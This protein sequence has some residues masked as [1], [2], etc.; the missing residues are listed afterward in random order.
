[1]DVSACMP[2]EYWPVCRFC[3]ITSRGTLTTDEARSPHIALKAVVRKG[4]VKGRSGGEEKVDDHEA[5]EM[6][7]V[8]DEESEDGVVDED[9][10]EEA[11]VAEVRLLLATCAFN[12]L[13][14][15]HS[16]VLNR[17]PP[18]GA[19]PTID[20]VKPFM[21][22]LLVAGLTS[23]SLMARVVDELPRRLA[24]ML[25]LMVSSGCTSAYAM[26]SEKA[27][28]RKWHWYAGHVSAFEWNT[29]S[30]DKG[31]PN[32][33]A[34]GEDGVDGG[35]AGRK[36]DGK[37]ERLS[38]ESKETGAE[39]ER[40]MAARAGDWKDEEVERV[41]V[42]RLEEG[43]EVGM[44]WDGTAAESNDTTLPCSII[45]WRICHAQVN[46]AKADRSGGIDGLKSNVS[47]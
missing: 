5:G 40:R 11:G 28:P 33:R 2:D 32:T 14:L 36:L 44:S 29:L 37:G 22:A 17:M 46:M 42:K 16:Y 27:P 30:D 20:T 8:E 45:R 21:T 41:E 25:V 10:A 19:A 18:C 12:T 6:V 31:R 35:W 24:W 9:E 26:A 4:W 43:R 38:P 15:T 34:G 23:A 39:R 47:E 13:H 3:V 1:M 7:A